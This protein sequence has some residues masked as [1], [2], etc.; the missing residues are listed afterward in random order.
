MFKKKYYDIID[1]SID[2]H[3]NLINILEQNKEQIFEI[4]MLIK[5][6]I[7]SDS[8][9]FIAGNGGSASDSSH[10]AAELTGKF[11]SKNRKPFKCIALIDSVTNITAI[12]NDF[13]YEEVFV[14][15][16]EALS[17]KGDLFIGLSTSGRSQNIIKSV[18][19]CKNNEINSIVFLGKKN[20]FKLKA[21]II[22]KVSSDETAR[23]QEIHYLILHLICELLEV[24]Y[25]K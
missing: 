15:Q 3:K 23:I 5:N 4:Y 13:S 14:K 25:I 1:E 22:H 9:I 2:K 10:F 11:K 21:D 6:T 8:N 20:P 24:D 17:R 19:Y 7:N 16:L 18:K 12:S